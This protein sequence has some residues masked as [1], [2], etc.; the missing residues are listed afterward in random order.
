MGRG[1]TK[2]PHSRS[3]WLCHVVLREEHVL[4]KLALSLW[5]AEKFILTAS[6]RS[7]G[8]ADFFRKYLR[9]ISLERK[10]VCM[11]VCVM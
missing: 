8:D 3:L 1:H 4:Q 7:F 6:H 11:C 2:L 5:L 9:D 10:G